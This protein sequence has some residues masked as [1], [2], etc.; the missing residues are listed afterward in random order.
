MPRTIEDLD[1]AN[2]FF[3]GVQGDKIVTLRGS[4]RLSRD[5]A[6]NLAAWL[7]V[8]ADRD[9]EFGLLLEKVQNS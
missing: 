1:A 4:L 6:L 5:E 2:H 8:L 3:V 9:D 7:V